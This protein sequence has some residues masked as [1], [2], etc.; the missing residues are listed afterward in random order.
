MFLQTMFIAILKAVG[1][2]WFEFKQMFLYLVDQL[3]I[4]WRRRQFL[5]RYGFR[6]STTL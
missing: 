6:F 1:M 2:I 4:G 5:N 3:I